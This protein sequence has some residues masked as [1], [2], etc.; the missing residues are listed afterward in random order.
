VSDAPITAGYS[1]TGWHVL[2]ANQTYALYAKLALSATVTRPTA[3]AL[4]VISRP[5]QRTTAKWSMARAKAGRTGATS[6]SYMST[7]TALQPLKLP[8]QSPRSCKVS[9]HGEFPEGG[10]TLTM[11]I[12]G[13]S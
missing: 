7:T 4:R 3:I 10:G 8:G 9:A 13:R 1:A 5:A 6:G 12:Y 11:K 2:A